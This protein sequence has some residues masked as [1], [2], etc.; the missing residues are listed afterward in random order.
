ML[1]IRN[2]AGAFTVDLKFE[3]ESAEKEHAR[4]K[5]K[6]HLVQTDETFVTTEINDMRTNV[7]LFPLCGSSLAW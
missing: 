7:L 1:Q 3:K 6:R 4:S 5:T 2:K